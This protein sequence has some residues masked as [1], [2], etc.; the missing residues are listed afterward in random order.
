[1]LASNAPGKTREADVRQWSLYQKPVKK[2]F[3]VPSLDIPM[4]YIARKM[5]KLTETHIYLRFTSVQT[6]PIQTTIESNS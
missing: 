4:I 6:K 2:V 5:T 3:K 1:M